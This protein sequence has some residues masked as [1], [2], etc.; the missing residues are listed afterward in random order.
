MDQLSAI[1]T[2]ERRDPFGC[3][4]KNYFHPPVDRPLTADLRKI[5]S[6]KRAVFSPKLGAQEESNLKKKAQFPPQNSPADRDL[7]ADSRGYGVI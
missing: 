2:A 6:P 3:G 1:S 7:L 4:R 5:G